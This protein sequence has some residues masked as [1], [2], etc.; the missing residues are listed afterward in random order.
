[1]K[2]RRVRERDEATARERAE[3]RAEGLLAQLKAHE[4]AAREP[5]EDKAPAPVTEP[6]PPEASPTEDEPASP[7]ASAVQSEPEV[8]DGR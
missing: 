6:E 4:A 3:A 8:T 2:R 5:V 7:S 1:M